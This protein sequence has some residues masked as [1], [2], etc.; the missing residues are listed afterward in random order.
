[1]SRNRKRAGRTQHRQSLHTASKIVELLWCSGRDSD[2]GLRL[3]RPEYLTGL[4]YRSTGLYCFSSLQKLLALSIYSYLVSV[5]V[6]HVFKS[7]FY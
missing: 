7:S 5:A 1:M 4:Y 3:E 2:P 6:A